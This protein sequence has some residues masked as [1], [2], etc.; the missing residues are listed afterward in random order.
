MDDATNAITITVIPPSSAELK[1]LGDGTKLFYNDKEFTRKVEAKQGEELTFV[2]KRKP[3][4]DIA[5]G[6][7]VEPDDEEKQEATAPLPSAMDIK[8]KKWVRPEEFQVKLEDKEGWIDGKELKIKINGHQLPPNGFRVPE[9]VCRR[10][11]LEITYNS[12][13]YDVY[14]TDRCDL[15]NIEKCFINRKTKTYVG[16][17][18]LKNGKIAHVEISSRYLSANEIPL[19]GYTL[20][21]NVLQYTGGAPTATP[22]E[23]TEPSEPTTPPKAPIPPK[24][25]SSPVPPPPPTG[26]P[27]VEEKKTEEPKEKVRD[28]KL[29]SEVLSE[30]VKKVRG[31]F[32]KFMKK[33]E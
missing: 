32:E 4:E 14:K 24:A 8:W 27:P 18:R 29:S 21:K 7:D 26:K 31:L 11:K 10:A 17:M 25:T 33:K 30:G 2:L 28:K 19:E 22:T 5:Y 20:V 23:P 9:S 12:N 15:L 16:E 13:D 1:E 3:F 6:W